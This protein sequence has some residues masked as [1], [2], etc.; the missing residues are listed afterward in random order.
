M[1]ADT[2]AK[3]SWCACWPGSL[4]KRNALR[5]AGLGKTGDDV[6]LEITTAKGEALRPILLAMKNWGLAWEKD[7]RAMLTEKPR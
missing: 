7:T 6:S 4:C 1:R 2:L 3:V 5:W